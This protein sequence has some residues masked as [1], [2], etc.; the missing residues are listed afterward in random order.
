MLLKS[1]ISLLYKTKRITSIAN[2]TNFDTFID[3]YH[4][5]VAVS[6]FLAV[7]VAGKC[8]IEPIQTH[9]HVDDKGEF[10]FKVESCKR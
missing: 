3:M 7:R 6:L 2:R 1:M 10:K 9:R 8:T 4:Y 5:L